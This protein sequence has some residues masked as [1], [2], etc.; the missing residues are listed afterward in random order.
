LSSGRK[1]LLVFDSDLRPMNG[2]ARKDP[3]AA[4][5]EFEIMHVVAYFEVV[6]IQ[7][8]LNLWQEERIIPMEDVE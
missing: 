5:Y 1:Q 8:N 3:K 4:P 2:D 6:L 7:T